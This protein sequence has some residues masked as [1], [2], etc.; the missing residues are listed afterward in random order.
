MTEINSLCFE[1]SR[2]VLDL[3][4]PREERLWVKIF[5]SKRV[6][7]KTQKK[8]GSRGQG[9]G[10]RG[11][12]QCQNILSRRVYQ[13]YQ[14]SSYIQQYAERSLNIEIKINRKVRLTRWSY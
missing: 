4:S 14:D 7:A 13:R 9:G 5:N 3:L 12:G 2:P 1:A 8:N 11:E 6:P 10:R